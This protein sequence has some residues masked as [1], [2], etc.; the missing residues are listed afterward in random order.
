MVAQALSVLLGAKIELCKWRGK[1]LFSV[2]KRGYLQ[3]KVV[4]LLTKLVIC[5]FAKLGH[6]THRGIQMPVHIK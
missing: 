4:L 2:W 6:K 5:R 3:K 1:S